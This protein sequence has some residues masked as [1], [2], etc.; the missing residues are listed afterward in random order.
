MGTLDDRQN[1]RDIVLGNLALLQVQA[2]IVSFVSAILSFGLGL[3][4]PRAHSESVDAVADAATA[5]FMYARTPKRPKLP[6]GH[7]K[8]GFNE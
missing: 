6:K 7:L 4:A 1:R 3:I 8:S 2:T 5:M